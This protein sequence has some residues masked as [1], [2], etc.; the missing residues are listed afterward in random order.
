MIGKVLIVVE[1]FEFAVFDFVE[2][3]GYL[4]W[5]KFPYHLSLFP[6]VCCLHSNYSNIKNIAFYLTLKTD[7]NLIFLFFI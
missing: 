6:T 5:M 4:I 7:T 3:D 2:E 1:F